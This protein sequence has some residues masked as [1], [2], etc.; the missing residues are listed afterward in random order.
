MDHGSSIVE[1]PLSPPL[2]KGEGGFS[3]LE[4]L[5]VIGLLAIIASAGIPMASSFL[6]RSGRQV[7]VDRIASEVYKAQNYAMNER[8]ISGSTTW[9]VCQTG[10]IF[11][12]FNGSCASPNYKEDFV[13]NNGVSVSGI[14]S[15]TF[16]NLRGLPSVATT[17]VVSNNFG[18]NSIVINAGGMVE[19]N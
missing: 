1:I 11:R 18:A 8:V 6:S 13:P 3:L 4:M 19:V 15:I 7:A 14:T 10:N 16:D 17:I 2:K 12:L 5:M 9:G